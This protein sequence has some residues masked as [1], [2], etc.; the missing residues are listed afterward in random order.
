MPVKFRV[1]WANLPATAKP[2]I[3]LFGPV[4]SG[5]LAVPFL[6]TLYRGD[7]I[8]VNILGGALVAVVVG[9]VLFMTFVLVYG[10]FR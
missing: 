10:R 5:V 6:I 2:N 3:I 7:G 1:W 8:L 4:L 9:W